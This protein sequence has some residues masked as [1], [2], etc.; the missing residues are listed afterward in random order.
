MKL[1]L[2]DIC[3]YI[4][5]CSCH[6]WSQTSISELLMMLLQRHSKTLLCFRVDCL[7]YFRS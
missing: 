1:L 7:E 3:D 2:Q 4:S 5:S 6:H